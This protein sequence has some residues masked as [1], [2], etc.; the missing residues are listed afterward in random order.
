PLQPLNGGAECSDEVY[1]SPRQSHIRSGPVHAPA[2]AHSP[3]REKL[4][5][6]TDSRDSR[7]NWILPAQ[8]SAL[9]VP[10]GR[11]AVPSFGPDD[12]KRSF[13]TCFRTK[14]RQSPDPRILFLYDDY[15]VFSQRLPIAH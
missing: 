1:R 5:R 14:L 3:V 12:L 15:N 4:P 6:Q 9:A 13:R 7:P 8:G 2:D 11:T 10:A